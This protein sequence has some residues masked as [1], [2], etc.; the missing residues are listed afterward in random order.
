MII[1]EGPDGG[2]KSTL[3][4][5][6]SEIMDIPIMKFEKRPENVNEVEE[7]I[8]YYY[9]N[10]NAI[11]D[12]FYLIS[13]VAYGLTL[14]K[15]SMIEPERFKS[16]WKIIKQVLDPILIWTAYKPRNFDQIRVKD[17]KDEQHIELVHKQRANILNIYD[18]LS[19]ALALIDIKS[20]FYDYEE[21]DCIDLY[22][23]FKQM[24]WL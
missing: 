3:A 16:E 20:C 2:G 19:V 11:Y 5:E 10:P 12:R 21:S 1:I 24:G 17:W 13:E 22:A 18:R 9:E 15:K 8:S 14:R 4:A 23:G 7:R 6:L